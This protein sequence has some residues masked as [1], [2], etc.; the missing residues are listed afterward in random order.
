MA[1]ACK[2]FSVG[3][4]MDM[5][6]TPFI[7]LVNPWITD[8]AAHDLWTKPMGLLILASLLR[9]GGC[10]VALVDCLDRHDPFTNAHPDVLPGHDKKFGT[11]KY[12]RMRIPKPE[13]LFEMPR[14]YY[15]HGIHPESFRKKLR[16][17]GS[18][19]L[20]CI[21]STMTYWYPGLRETVAVLREEFP[22]V[23]VWLGGIYATLCPEHAARFG[24]ADR[25]IP[26]PVAGFPD[27]LK[28]QTGFDLTNRAD[29]A[30]F[31]NWPPP[32][33]DLMPGR[34]YAPILTGVGCPYRCPYCASG[35]L[36]PRR[37]RL[38]PERI[39]EEIARG[40]AELGIC[41]F[42]FYDDALLLDARG[43]LWPALERIVKEGL[44]VRFHVPNALHIRALSR[45]WCDLLFA[46][47][48]RTLR[49]GLETTLD[50]KSREWGGKVDTEMFLA[51]LGNL[52][53]AGFDG[54]RIG[55]YLLC[56]LPGQTPEE[57]GRAVEFVRE[58]GVRP[59]IAEYSPIPGTPMW[60]Q[61]VECSRYD[62]AGEPLFHNNS[63]FACR[64]PDFTYEDMLAL[65]KLARMP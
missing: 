4:G 14:F 19:D 44:P 47:G 63:F 22:G 28:S 59:H 43:T 23:P 50:S 29:W 34:D 49:L 38:G 40:H 1:V 61:A 27:L 65:K 24:G 42:A 17:T 51:G 41:D 56:G 48:F 13:P 16:C 20:I 53:A 2:H 64:R 11:G 9:N 26:G 5:S 54:S 21:G 18:P 60:K 6:R 31:R 33:L 55:V 8:F 37:E 15:R 39:Y 46:S 45:D 10:G 3:T 58:R 32:A 57:V 30:G 35:R 7:L 12:P 52:F 36:Q 25:I 62:I